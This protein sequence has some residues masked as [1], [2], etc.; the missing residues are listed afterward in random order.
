MLLPHGVVFFIHILL[1]SNEYVLDGLHSHDYF[2]QFLASQPTIMVSSPTISF[3]CLSLSF[4]KNNRFI[5]S[6]P[7]KCLWRY[8]RSS[9]VRILSF[10]NMLSYVLNIFNI[11]LYKVWISCDIC[12]Y[13]LSFA[14]LH[15]I[16]F[17]IC[18][19]IISKIVPVIKIH[20]HKIKNQLVFCVSG[21][22][23]K[24]M[25]PNHNHK[26]VFNYFRAVGYYFQS[27]CYIVSFLQTWTRKL[28]DTLFD[29][30]FFDQTCYMKRMVGSKGEDLLLAPCD[31]CFQP[32]NQ[33]MIYFSYVSKPMCP[34]EKINETSF[35]WLVK[36]VHELRYLK[37]CILTWHNMVFSPKC[38]CN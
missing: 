20:S 27:W 23:S 2:F 7:L 30:P 5:L 15:C 3:P 17:S 22:K 29:D 38:F 26:P 9:S 14:E 21:Y 1:L 37:T 36:V 16:E 31:L 10:K 24:M 28:L 19:L 4:Q 25:E 33:E 35:I 11:I 8:R 13:I 18:F 34:I 32:C 12:P 6:S